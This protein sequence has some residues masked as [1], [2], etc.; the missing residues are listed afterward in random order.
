MSFAFFQ[1]GQEAGRMRRSKKTDLLWVW[2]T[3]RYT[4]PHSSPGPSK[5]EWVRGDTA[6]NQPGLTLLCPPFPRWEGT[7]WVRLCWV[8]GGSSPEK[9]GTGS[10]RPVLFVSS[11]WT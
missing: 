6:L 10:A 4:L 5:S 11:G 7:F 8:R 2:F 9:P 1:L 3:H